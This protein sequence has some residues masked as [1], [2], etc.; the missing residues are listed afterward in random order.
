[1]V[2]PLLVPQPR[3]GEAPSSRDGKHT[4]MHITY[5]LYDGGWKFAIVIQFI[6]NLTLVRPSVVVDAHVVFRLNLIR[7]QRP[8]TTFKCRIQLFSG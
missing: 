8:N 3:L 5:R 7:I 6:G 2:N 1:M 4:L